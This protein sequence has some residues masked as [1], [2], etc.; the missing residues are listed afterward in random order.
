[1]IHVC[2]AFTLSAHTPTYSALTQLSAKT[3]EE[4]NIFWYKNSCRKRNGGGLSSCFL[5]GGKTEARGIKGGQV[6][7]RSAGTWAQSLWLQKALW[8]LFRSGKGVAPREHL[9]QSS[10]RGP[11]SL[12]A[13]MGWLQTSTAQPG[14]PG[15]RTT[16]PDSPKKSSVGDRNSECQE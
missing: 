11:P 4:S 9:S 6:G 12:E 13:G 14:A 8:V 2:L 5:P 1:M 7:K 15:P 10:T 3:K 16:V